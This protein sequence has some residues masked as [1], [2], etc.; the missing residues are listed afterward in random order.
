M[1]DRLLT[2]RSEVPYDPEAPVVAELRRLGYVDLRSI[3]DEFDDTVTKTS[4]AHLRYLAALL[5]D[6]DRRKLSEAIAGIVSNP[7]LHERDIRLILDGRSLFDPT[8]RTREVPVEAIQTVGRML[9][10][11]HTIVETARAARVCVNTVEAIDGYLGLT[12]ARADR[13][14]DMAVTAVREGWSVRVL[15]RAANIS[16][17]QAHRLMVQARNVLV[18]IGEVAQ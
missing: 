7:N 12:Q 4:R 9:I 10:A 8:R 14:M 11:G 18:E 1:I 17:S 2:P 3:A 6:L 13:L 15:G 16:K 5:P